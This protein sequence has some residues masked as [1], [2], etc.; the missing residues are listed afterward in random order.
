MITSWFERDDIPTFSEA[1]VL[2]PNMPQPPTSDMDLN[3]TIQDGTATDNGNIAEDNEEDDNH[4]IPSM[5]ERNRHEDSGSDNRDEDYGSYSKNDEDDAEEHMDV[6]SVTADVTR[7]DNN[8]DT[9]VLLENPFEPGAYDDT[10]SKPD[11]Q[12]LPSEVTADNEK[13][14]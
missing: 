3:I 4:D 14:L 2:E 6:G 8:E 7:N 12:E 11:D 1:R 9:P 10:L 13:L 5:T